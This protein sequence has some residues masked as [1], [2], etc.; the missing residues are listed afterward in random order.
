MKLQPF[1]TILMSLTVM[2][3]NRLRSLVRVCD[4]V[5]CEMNGANELAQTLDNYFKGTVRVQKVPCIGRCQSAPAAVVKMNP[6]DNATFEKTKS[7]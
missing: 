1:I 6:V 4:S 3:I 5:S 7:C 2:M